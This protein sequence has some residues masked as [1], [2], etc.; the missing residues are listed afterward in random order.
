M[1]STTTELGVLSRHR[2]P[3]PSE[4]RAVPAAPQPTSAGPVS[5][6]APR[7]RWATRVFLPA[8]LLLTAGALLAYAARDALV[9]ATPVRVV[10]V[11]VRAAL[12]TGISGGQEFAGGA[13]VQAPG[14][15]EPDPH[16][17]SVAAL[18]DGVVKE[19]LA[20]EGQAVE[21]GQVVVRLVD[22]DARLAVARAEADVAAKEAELAA[23]RAALAAAQR[24]WDNPVERRRAV[25]SGEAMLAEAAAELERQPLEVEAEQARADEL[26]EVAKRTEAKA[27]QNAVTGAELIQAR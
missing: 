1:P 16:P 27:A 13:T 20:L 8:G 25:A 10:P 19:V 4:P 15:V 24:D 14:W 7:R 12:G 11:V 9:P 26:A 18:A 5:V 17:V 23:A 3:A 2:T 22:E 21:A 6:P